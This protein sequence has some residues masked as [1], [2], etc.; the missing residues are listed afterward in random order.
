MNDEVTEPWADPDEDAIDILLA[1]HARVREELDALEK[2]LADPARPMVA[3]VGGSKVSTKLTVLE[4]L[5]AFATTH[6]ATACLG[7]T[8]YQAAQ[9]TTVGKRACLWA[10]DLIDD[11]VAALTQAIEELGHFWM[12]T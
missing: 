5:G 8:H 11:L 7:Y 4:A 1:F 9:L 2:A 10:R 3:I 6:R 12:L